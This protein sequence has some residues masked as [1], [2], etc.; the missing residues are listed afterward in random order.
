MRAK[1]AN[2]NRA[3][4][5]TTSSACQTRSG[6]ILGVSSAYRVPHLVGRAPCT[7][8]LSCRA[9]KC[10]SNTA[11]WA[12]LD[13]SNKTLFQLSHIHSSTHWN[14][15]L[16]PKLSTH[17]H[18]DPPRGCSMAVEYLEIT[19]RNYL[20]LKVLRGASILRVF[21]RNTIFWEILLGH[22]VIFFYQ[23]LQEFF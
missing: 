20:I 18:T 14:Y 7:S 21:L 1:A 3:T 6:F 12:Y 16:A 10:I 22:L 5:I 2:E 8:A 17:A 4:N 9:M 23:L 11:F 13:S 19:S 15:T